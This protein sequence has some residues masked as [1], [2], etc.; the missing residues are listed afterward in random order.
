M[1]GK[2]WIINERIHITMYSVLCYLNQ[3]EQYLVGYRVKSSQT[4]SYTYDIYI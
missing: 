3:F 4:R 1:I 2:I